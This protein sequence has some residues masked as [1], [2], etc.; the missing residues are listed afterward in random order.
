MVLSLDS[1][2]KLLGRFKT[3]R[4]RYKKEA[5]GLSQKFERTFWEVFISLVILWEETAASAEIAL[6]TKVNRDYTSD[7]YVLVY[8]IFH[9][10]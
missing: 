6:V 1:K 10:Q 2:P 8:C 5:K 7:F 3:W 4:I 9:L